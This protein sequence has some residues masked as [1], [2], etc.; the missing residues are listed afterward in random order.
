MAKNI[1][2]AVREICL[3]L[4]ESDEVVS[5]GNPNFRVNKKKPSPSS[6]SIIM[7]MVV[8]ACG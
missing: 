3:S 7:A 6:W 8:S 4:P 5:R 2:D 1:R